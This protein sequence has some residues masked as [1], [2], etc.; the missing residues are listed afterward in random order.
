[1]N[2]S[3]QHAIPTTINGNMHGIC[4]HQNMLLNTCI[5][6]GKYS[7]SLSLSLAFSLS[8]SPLPLAFSVSLS[9]SLFLPLSLSL[10]RFL[11]LSPYL[12]FFLSLS[13]F[14]DDYTVTA[15]FLVSNAIV[16]EVPEVNLRMTTATA[17]DYRWPGFHSISY[18]KRYWL[19]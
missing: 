8:L 13:T 11:C 1:M 3:T 6:H 2:G 9:Q 17:A 16:N 15:I 7:L 10:S 14:G 5:G 12:T 19:I 18:F 4:P